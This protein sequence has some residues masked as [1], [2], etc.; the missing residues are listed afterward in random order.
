MPGVS[1]LL[2]CAGSLGGLP[3]IQG[4]SKLKCDHAATLFVD[5]HDGDLKSISIAGETMTI[6]PWGS[7]SWFSYIVENIVVV[8]APPPPIARAKQA[9]TQFAVGLCVCVQ[10]A[11]KAAQ[12]VPLSLSLSRNS[13]CC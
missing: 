5:I 9:R 6:I 8:G 2:L 13:F 3:P 11:T 7:R 10:Y 1:L 12:V 4:T